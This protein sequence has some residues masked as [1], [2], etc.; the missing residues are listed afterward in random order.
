[1][2]Y[3]TSTII[4][5]TAARLMNGTFVL[6]RCIQEC[7]QQAPLPFMFLC[8]PPTPEVKRV[9]VMDAYLV[10]HRVAT[11][12]VDSSGSGACFF[13]AALLQTAWEYSSFARRFIALRDGSGKEQGIRRIAAARRT[14]WRGCPVFRRVLMYT[15]SS[16][17][18][19]KA[20]GDRCVLM[21]FS[22]P[23]SRLFPPLWRGR[24]S[25]RTRSSSG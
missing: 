17:R 15:Y 21:R 23:F 4:S 14:C 13:R 20:R 9:H 8:T 11:T 10:V 3:F 25:W 2:W 19:P 1:M 5:E 12:F 24:I 18:T 22:P 16:Y 6:S 7:V